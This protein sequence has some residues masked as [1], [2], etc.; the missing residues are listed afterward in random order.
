MPI[1]TDVPP[2]GPPPPGFSFPFGQA[3]RLLAALEAGIDDLVDLRGV[4]L[5]AAG[6]ARVGFEGATRAR[7]DAALAAGLAD[8]ETVVAGLR[9]DAAELEATIG[10][11]RA[12]EQDAHRALQA[13]R[14]RA[15]AYEQALQAQT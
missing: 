2:P 5:D 4:H 7:L 10:V 1:V 14:R 6:Q 11:A 9:A 12:R 13:W 8:L 3:S 15:H